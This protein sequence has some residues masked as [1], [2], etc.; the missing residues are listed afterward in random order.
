MLELI[1]ED[2]RKKKVSAYN[3][4]YREN[5]KELIQSYYKKS[6]EEKSSNIKS[7]Q[8]QYYE[9]FKN[10]IE[11]KNGILISIA[12]DYIN[13]HS[14]LSVICPNDHDFE[15]SLNN[16]TN[17]KWCPKCNI[18]INE[19]I[20][21]CA[22]EHLFD[23]QFNKVRPDWLKNEQ[24]NNLEIDCFNEELKL[25]VE[26]N[27]IQHYEF[28][29]YFHKT[30]ENFQKRKVD[31]KIKKDKCI[32]KNYTFIEIPYTIPTENIINYI[33]KKCNE[34]NIICEQNKIDTFD[35]SEIDISATKQTKLLDIIREKN[36][37]LINGNYIIRS[38]FVNIRCDKNHI[39]QTRAG[40]II[41]GSWC[42]TCKGI[43]TE[44]K[45]KNISTGMILYNQTEEGKKKKKES[46]EKRSLTMSAQ[47]EE[48][49]KDLTE[50]CCT[51]CKIIK[52]TTE[53]GKKT[54]TKD[55]F[56]P[57][58]RACI[59]DIKKNSRQNKIN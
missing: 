59:N 20:T 28:I 26:Y 22:L 4:K 48:F 27:G 31:D 24:G 12:D 17:N 10:T 36:G 45:K 7:R 15:I 29:E 46:L 32:E 18:K 50:K 8:M 56:Q 6:D 16:L 13:A 3:K 14:K 57:Y 25:C 44:G 38:S 43:M 47:K 1:S 21:L 51:K 34:A 41:H 19:C 58:C 35:I 37:E 2:L 54:D 52:N 55:G 5:N 30:E 11:K 23:K 53:F 40:K 9:E 39:W 49:R 33:V 42:S